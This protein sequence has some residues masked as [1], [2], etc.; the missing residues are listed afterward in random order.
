MPPEPRLFDR[1]RLAEWDFASWTEWACRRRGLGG[2][3]IA[4]VAEAGPGASP[5]MVV[6]VVVVVQQQLL[7]VGGRSVEWG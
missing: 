5:S 7:Q 1:V 6:V 3:C 2:L 4:R